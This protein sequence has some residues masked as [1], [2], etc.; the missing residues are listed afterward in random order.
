MEK[1]KRLN[2]VNFDSYKP[3]RELVLE[4]LREAILNGTLQPRERLMEIQ[5]ADELGVSR[6]PIR[7]ALRKLELEGF[8]IMVPRKGAYVADFSL[9]DLEDIF[10]V[11]KSLEGLA[12]E[13]AAERVTEEE[14]IKL[15]Q[16]LKEKSKAIENNDM[17]KLLDV[18][19]AFHEKLYEASRNERL[20][21]MIS[22]LREQIERF[23]IASL[24]YPGRMKRSLEEHYQILDAIQRR[25]GETA[26]RLAHA[27]IENVETILLDKLRH[28][29]D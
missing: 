20:R 23:R 8:I 16:L 10:E 6:T 3:L 28:S 5:L 11:R 17:Q 27:H 15:E 7:E 21:S 2:P 22:N 12:A 25:D 24:Q 18:D 19:T 29:Q 14:L 26:N 1:E 9:R 13:L 4:A